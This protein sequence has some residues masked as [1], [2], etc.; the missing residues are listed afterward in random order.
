MPLSKEQIKLQQLL[1]RLIENETTDQELSLLNEWFEKTPS[2]VE[3]Y[4]DFIKDYSIIRFQ[5]A[6]EI[7]APSA[8]HDHDPF[9]RAIWLELQRTENTAPAVN[10]ERRD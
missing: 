7:D 10:V 3:E 1:I 9:D 2:A 8:S 4:C 6:S 5:V